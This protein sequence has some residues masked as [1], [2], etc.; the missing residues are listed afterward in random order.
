MTVITVPY[1]LES[2]KYFRP[3]GAIINLVCPEC[4]AIVT[5]D[6]GDGMIEYPEPSQVVDI[7]GCNCGRN[8]KF[9]MVIEIVA[10]I[11]YEQF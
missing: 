4:G 5:A 7:V 11:K 3:D 8:I 9:E 1:D 2:I 6:L 10:K